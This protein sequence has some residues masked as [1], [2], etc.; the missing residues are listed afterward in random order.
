MDI[1]NQNGDFLGR[2]QMEAQESDYVVDQIIRTLK[3]GDGKAIYI[4]NAG[5]HQFTQ[6]TNYVSC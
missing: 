3:P 1:N 5:E 2:I 4:A 6:Q